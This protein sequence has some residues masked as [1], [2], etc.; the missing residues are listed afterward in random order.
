[1]EV[2]AL[3]SLESQKRC[4]KELLDRVFSGE[5]F[6]LLAGD[7]GTGRTVV[8]EQ[9]VNT[10]DSKLPAVFIPCQRDMQLQRLR[11][12]FLQQM[13]PNTEFDTSINLADALSQVHIPHNNKILVVVDD[14]DLVVSSF[15]NELLALHEQFLGQERFAF[16]L[17]CQPLWAEEKLSRY[18]GKSD[19]SLVQMPL[20]NT[21]EAMVLSR[22]IFAINNTMRI[23][24]AI[25]NK[26][27]DALSAAKGNLSQIINI[28]EKLMKEP[29][30]PPV[31]TD[32]AGKAVKNG[33]AGGRKKSSSVGIFVTIVCIIIVLACLIPIFFGGNFFSEEEGQDIQA[34]VANEDSLVF[35][36][37]TRDYESLTNDDGL[38]PEQVPGGIDAETARR[39]TEHSVTLS[40]DELDKIEGGV[41]NS[42][43]PR[44]VGANVD[45]K[46][47]QAPAPQ[48]VA[49]LRR[50]DNFN[51][52][53]GKSPVGVTTAVDVSAPPQFPQALDN[54]AVQEQLAR[55]TAAL[56]AAQQKAALEKAAQEK[57]AADRRQA[58][59]AAAAAAKAQAEAQAKAQAEALA[60]AEAAKAEAARK[61][62][63][64]EA[65]RQQAQQTAQAA[66]PVRPVQPARPALKAGQVINLGDEMRAEAAR[67]NA[68]AN[69]NRRPAPTANGAAV[70]G[71]MAELR[72]INGNHYAVQI[73]SA[74]NRANIVAAAQG[75]S[76]RFWV[77]E[78]VRNG[79]PWYILVYGDYASRQEAMAA[80]ANIPRSVSQGASPFA[81]RM[82]EI[83]NEIRR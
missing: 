74:S 24:K 47:P 9:V 10:T 16:I 25:S 34:Q 12:L 78:S 69:T 79:R 46:A 13:L 23:Y 55:D 42:G 52:V 7:S 8:C 27:P 4:C 3:A 2:E 67:Q 72:A 38:L 80:A 77:V 82:G 81:R 64:A 19:I 36:Q 32:K 41:N 11:E 18:T 68:N 75:L 62:A 58:E 33:L 56:Q 17:V 60:Q 50:G 66:Q 5:A 21:A 37:G 73:V 14:A 30:M 22:H 35:D 49:V 20:L 71:S 28:T 51:H 76:G 6:I 59:A 39:Q 26:L 44:G 40:G 57:I 45:N 54:R 29:T 61:A 1:M 48:Q 70:E 83:Q 65:S 63:Q 15:Y 53:N 31:S 43:Y